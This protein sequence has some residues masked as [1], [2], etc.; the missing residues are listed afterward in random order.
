MEYKVSTIERI[1]E[2]L[3]GGTAQKVMD[4]KFKTKAL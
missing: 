3:G 1:K 2:E 4:Y